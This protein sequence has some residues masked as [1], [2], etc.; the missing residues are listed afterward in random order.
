[1]VAQQKWAR[2][3][4]RRPGAH[5]A[6]PRGPLG[7]DTLRP[8]IPSCTIRKASRADL[9]AVADL[10]RACFGD[11]GILSFISFVQY[12]ELFPSYFFVAQDQARVVGFVV[13]GRAEDPSSAWLLDIA[14]HA[15]FRRMGVAIALGQAALG[16]LFRDGACRAFAT[17]HPDNVG[18][19]GLLSRLG[20][21]DPRLV[22]DYFG[23][24]EPR[25]V[26]EAGG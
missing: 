21:S 10:E 16:S 23:P 25:Y 19:R 26:V 20:F 22:A 7:W 14:V 3:S 1:M 8:M 17:V 2:K 12:F 11:A 9:R 5:V 6:R 24:G 13:A 15:S 4:V 18:S